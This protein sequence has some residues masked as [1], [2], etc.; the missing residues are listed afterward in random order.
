M[1]MAAGLLGLRLDK[2][3]VYVLGAEHAAPTASDIARAVRLVW[4]A[5]LLS[6]ACALGCV[7]SIGLRGLYGT[8]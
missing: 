5:G 3:G 1:A 7:A 2:P 4:S 6:F 8:A